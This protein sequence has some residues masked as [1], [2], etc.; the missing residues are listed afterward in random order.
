MSTTNRQLRREDFTVGWV[1]ALPVELAAAQ[2][3]LDEELPTPEVTA[4]DT[5]IY[6]CG[7]IGKHNV[8]IACLPDGQTGTNSAAAVA[9]QMKST[10][11]SIRF[12]LMVGIGGGVPS[13]DADVRLGDIVVSKPH[14][15][16]GG[17]VQYDFGKS[18]PNGF[19]RTGTLNTPPTILLNAV[20]SLKAKHL[21]GKSQL[22]EFH[23]KLKKLPDYNRDSAGPDVL[24]E[25]SYA[26]E[27]GQTCVNCGEAKQVEREPRDQIRVHYGTIASGNQVM[28]DALDRD[29]V[30]AG[31]GHV[32]CFEM[33]AAGLMNS[34]P[35]LVIRGIC[36]YADS[37][38]NKRW[39][40]Y[41]AGTAAAYAK[42]LLSI[43]PEDEVAATTKAALVM[44]QHEFLPL[45][46]DN[47]CMYE[48]SKSRNCKRVP[49]T[50]EWFTKHSLFQGWNS[51][52]NDEQTGLL[53]VTADP[54]CGKSVLSRYL[55]DD[56]LPRKGRTV[57]YFF[58]KDDV[59]FQKGI[60]R[61]LCSV[62]HQLLS[63]NRHLLTEDLL[64]LY[65]DRGKNFFGSFP[66]LWSTFVLATD[67][68][69]TVCV[70]DALD[71]CAEQDRKDLTDAIALVCNAK[72]DRTN[73]SGKLRFLLTSRPHSH[74]AAGLSGKL[75][76]QLA[77]IHIQGDQ[78]PT[79]EAIVRE[80][81][82]VLESRIKETADYF[83]M[84]TDERALMSNQFR[85]VSNRTYLWISLTFSGLMDSK[86]GI[87]K[88]DIMAL[89]K[90]L[91]QSIHGAYEKILGRSPD[92][93]KARR[94]LLIV[95]G[96]RR[97][98]S[99]TEIPIAIAFQDSDT[100]TS[101][102]DAIIP[103]SRIRSHI[104][105]LCGLFVV[106]VDDKVYLLHQT[107]KE[108]LLRS[109]AT[110]Q[111]PQSAEITQAKNEADH[112]RGS[113]DLKESHTVLAATCIMYLHVS[114]D[115]PGLSFLDYAA[116]HWADHYRHSP[117]DTQAELIA[118]ARDL[119]VAG[120]KSRWMA[121]V[122]GNYHLPVPPSALRLASAL[123]LTNL[124]GPLIEELKLTKKDQYDVTREMRQALS[125]AA[126]NGH[127]PIIQ[128][129]LTSSK[130]S[131]ESRSHD[132]KYDRAPLAYAASN[133]HE[134]AVKLLL[135]Y[136]AVVD[137]TDSIGRTALSLA[138]EN[139]HES[140]V[141]LL[142]Q[143]K[144]SVDATG[145]VG[146]TPLYYAAMNEHVNIV[147]ILIQ[148]GA[149]VELQNGD[150]MSLLASAS[151]SGHL[152]AV[153]TLLQHCKVAVDSRD[154]LGRTPLW[155][156][157]FYRHTAV[158]KALLQIGKARVDTVPYVLRQTPLW[159]A[160]A[161]G[162]A[163]TVQA[164]LQYGT[165]DVNWRDDYY[166]RPPLLCAVY[167]QNLNTVRLLLD[168]NKVD[169]NATDKNHQAPLLLAVALD[170]ESLIKL[171]LDKGANADCRNKLGRTPLSLKASLPGTAIIELL[172]TTRKAA[173]DAPDDYGR[174]PLSH[175]A[176]RGRFDTVRLLVEVGSADVNARD[177]CFCRT[178]LVYAARGGH[179]DIVAFLLQ[180]GARTHVGDEWSRTALSY[181]AAHGYEG[182]VKLLLVAGS[183]D[184]VLRD[185]K[186][187]TPLDHAVKKR[188]AAIVSLLQLS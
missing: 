148:H 107:A 86:L 56:V 104:R 156:A 102:A 174:T 126:R 41:A 163:D 76:T 118:Q 53:Y 69:D 146:R 14:Q 15:V 26:H 145:L 25:A 160:A 23:A 21:R 43:V 70:F 66:N 39:Q 136:K 151:A 128:L 137:T 129:F 13:D 11:T 5:N 52:S 19:E 57:C 2:E 85:S 95:L 147:K 81:D 111:Q 29:R 91:P 9:A 59:E 28:R 143:N 20:A 60:T 33:E 134:D 106:I 155:S 83:S 55:V 120:G 140:M 108:F 73:Q 139:G 152:G 94:L 112:W 172:L 122:H 101:T 173:V 166:L 186:G 123:G 44:A 154:M 109:N 113:F 7:Q 22:L 4:Y 98:L 75:Q 177:E 10:F 37:H 18:T 178:P 50:C 162:Y 49:G 93:E 97:P 183:A 179:E 82:L 157:A 96:A 3:M 35:C 133:G 68:V 48:D 61:A 45:L 121:A 27:G 188:H 169:M 119:C 132:D 47:A 158:I 187:R 74:I 17:V 131:V 176:E 8:V 130:I 165:P 31:L 12:G 1:C 87:C 78:G 170:N 127:G 84:D 36:D 77:S 125:S 175:A 67:R 182:I 117:P 142:L 42:E 24:F 181:A 99:L 116:N 161:Q 88:D 51:S 185:F 124:V 114:I 100:G 38:K 153:K 144:A 105:E 64:R 171:L 80:I 115:T 62:L 110:P 141:L 164:L 159:Y 54:G 180:H 89:T 16:H 149:D 150:G 79:A 34:F 72:T 167:I 184:A 6:S 135:R 90:K 58:F 40:P 65:L 32:L 138:A 92:P 46:Y 63:A 71:E 168:T 30:S 103:Q